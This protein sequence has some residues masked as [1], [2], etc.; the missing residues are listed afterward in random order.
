MADRL[1]TSE[2]LDSIR[3]LDRLA[4]DD[5]EAATIQRATP[6]IV[7]GKA[8]KYPLGEGLCH[9]V[10]DPLHMEFVVVKAQGKRGLFGR[11]KPK[12]TVMMGFDSGTSWEAG[13]VVKSAKA[14]AFV[15]TSMEKVDRWM[16][17]KYGRKR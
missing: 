9:L 2:M 17:E 3:Q 1:T 10:S 16:D 8:A 13:P 5:A 12:Y 15:L 6:A 7:A 4:Y 11:P 14:V